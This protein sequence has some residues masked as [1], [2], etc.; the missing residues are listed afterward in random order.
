MQDL[1]GDGDPL[2]RGRSFSGGLCG[3]I[4]RFP[5]ATDG[6]YGALGGRHGG[7][8]ST[9]SSSPPW[10]KKALDRPILRSNP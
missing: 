9:P 3:Q 2:G 8:F 5:A 6:I 7:R 1:A 10:R 4:P